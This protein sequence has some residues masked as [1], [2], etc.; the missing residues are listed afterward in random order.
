MGRD[1]LRNLWPNLIDVKGGAH[2]VI[3]GAKH[4]ETMGEMANIAFYSLQIIR[5]HVCIA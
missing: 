5:P 2:G 3:K 4:A 1:W